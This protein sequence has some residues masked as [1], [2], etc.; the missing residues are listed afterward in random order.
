DARLRHS[1]KLQTLGL[2]TSSIVHEFNNVLA[3]ILGY[4]DLLLQNIDPKDSIYEDI[5]EIN[6]GAIMAKDV[7]GQVSIFSREESINDKIRP[8]NISEVI[9]SSLKLIGPLIPRNIELAEIYNSNDQV[10]GH[11]SK[12]QQ[13][14]L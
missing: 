2:L 7:I 3:P 12:L 11:I 8:E 5:E 9:K 13:V 4:S 14:F 1:Q 6:K 10:L